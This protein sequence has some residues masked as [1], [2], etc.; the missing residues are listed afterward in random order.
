MST[1]Q[2]FIVQTRLEECV[3]KLNIIDA[4]LHKKINIFLSRAQIYEQ[5]HSLGLNFG[6]FN[7]FL[8]SELTYDTYIKLSEEKNM[9]SNKLENL[10][11]G[12]DKDFNYDD[13]MNMHNKACAAS[14]R[15]ENLQ[16]QEDNQDCNNQDI[17]ST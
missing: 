5:F 14:E 13:Y 12:T 6:M 4:V 8:L 11:K 10:K 16:N 1:E 15:W 17:N 9:L 7:R 3:D 2:E